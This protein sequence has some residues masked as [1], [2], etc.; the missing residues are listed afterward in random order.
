MSEKSYFVNENVEI[1]CDNEI[2]L[3]ELSVEEAEVQINDVNQK[4]EFLRI[5]S[6]LEVEN[7]TPAENKTGDDVKLLTRKRSRN[8]KKWKT[9]Q[10]KLKCQSG[11][12]RQLF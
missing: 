12:K 2:S 9:T 3:E 5:E 11:K 6:I 1:S 4:V 10:R 8:P 7:D